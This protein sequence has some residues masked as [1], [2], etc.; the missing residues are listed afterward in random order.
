MGLLSALSR[1]VQSAGSKCLTVACAVRL[2]RSASTFQSRSPIILFD[3]LMYAPY[4]YEAHLRLQVSLCCSTQQ[5]VYCPYS[6]LFCTASVFFNTSSKSPARRWQFH[7]TIIA[8]VGRLSTCPC[9]LSC[10][11]L[12]ACLS[13]WSLAPCPCG[14]ICVRHLPLR[15]TLLL[16]V[17]P[18]N[19]LLI[20]KDAEAGGWN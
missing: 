5:H 18:L 10:L 1:A 8:P 7:C 2:M 17:V 11:A 20:S 9:G 3:S 13:R 12:W 15:A 19:S 6:L 16:V 4:V 14:P